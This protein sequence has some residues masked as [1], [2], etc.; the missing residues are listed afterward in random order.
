M[1]TQTI[2]RWLGITPEEEREAGLRT[3][4]SP[5]RR[6]E[7]AAVAGKVSGQVRARKAAAAA[8]EVLRL[9]EEGRSIREIAAELGVPRST[10]HRHLSAPVEKVSHEPV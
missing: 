9:R 1:R 3:L 4:V 8:Q 10:V 2:R 5:E 7:L 6:R